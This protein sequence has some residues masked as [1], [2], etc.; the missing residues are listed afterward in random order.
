MAMNKNK[1]SSV[2]HIFSYYSIVQPV[3]MKFLFYNRKSSYILLSGI[4]H[5]INDYLD[6]LSHTMCDS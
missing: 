2:N 1:D 3:T 4:Y 6:M 5:S